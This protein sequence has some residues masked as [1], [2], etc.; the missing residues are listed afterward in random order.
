VQ[1][2]Q[3]AQIVQSNNPSSQPNKTNNNV[4]KREQVPLRHGGV[5]QKEE[6]NTVPESR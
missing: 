1:F 2:P 3:R 6:S 5:P 4:P